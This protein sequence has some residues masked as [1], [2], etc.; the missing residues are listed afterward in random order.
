M[1][2]A[3]LRRHPTDVKRLKTNNLQ[4]EYRSSDR[5][6]RIGA[7]LGFALIAA[8]AAIDLTADISQGT[9]LLHVVTESAV[10][11]IALFGT[12]TMMLRLLSEARSAKVTAT[13][14]RLNLVQTQK[15]AGEW[16]AEAKSLLQGLGA[17]IG[18]QFDRWQ[19]SPVEKDVALFLLKG[20]SHKEV[21]QIRGVSV[22][23]ARQQAHMIYQKAGIAGRHDLA[24]FFL[25]DLALPANTPEEDWRAS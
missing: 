22:A 7:L 8:F 11:S 4:S 3:T 14:L 9:T 13:E 2:P 21:A 19:L 1:G 12:I 20:L 6:L 24:A 25:E 18:Q 17:S 15:A 23:T 10:V 5:A 16:R